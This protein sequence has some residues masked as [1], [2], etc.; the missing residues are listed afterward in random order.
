VYIF[1][2]SPSFNQNQGDTNRYGLVNGTY[3]VSTTIFS[4]QATYM[5]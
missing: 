2:D 5:F 4:L 1:A 3:D